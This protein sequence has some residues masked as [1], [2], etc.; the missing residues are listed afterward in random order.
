M[1]STLI[2][3]TALPEMRVSS[4]YYLSARITNNDDNNILKVI[5]GL[6]ELYALG[7][8][9]D[10]G[11]LTPTGKRMS[12]LPLDPTLSKVLLY[13][14]ELECTEEVVSV[15]AL[16]SVDT[17]FFSPKD[18]RDKAEAAKKK[19]LTN[20]GDHITLLNVLKTFRLTKDDKDWCQENFIN[21]RSM[22][23]VMVS[24]P[25]PLL[26]HLFLILLGLRAFLLFALG[27][28]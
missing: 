16:L 25:Q 5:R 13:S 1:W 11:K 24:C 20:E 22:K 17:I 26:K 8:L 23:Q 21:T 18:K 2:T 15:I 6:E 7:A 12:E 27:C 10:Q 28:I 14:Q 4:Y 9:N 3:W 19:F